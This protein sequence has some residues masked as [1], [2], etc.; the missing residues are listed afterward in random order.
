MCLCAFVSIVCVHMCTPGWV[1][2]ASVCV[3]SRICDCVSVYL[4]AF[5]CGHG[6]AS[7]KMCSCN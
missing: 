1:S 7:L 4:G 6:L 5:E 2:S 3:V